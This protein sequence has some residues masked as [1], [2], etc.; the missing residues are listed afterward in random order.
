MGSYSLG[1]LLE[2]VRVKSFPATSLRIPFPVQQRQARKA[3]AL[4]EAGNVLSG[5][6]SGLSLLSLIIS[7]SKVGVTELRAEAGL[8]RLWEPPVQGSL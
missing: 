4:R 1:F 2:M 7:L 5:E 3:L 8:R 6:P